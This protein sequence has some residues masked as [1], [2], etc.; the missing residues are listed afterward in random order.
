MIKLVNVSK[1]YSTKTTITQALRNINIEFKPGEF[2]AITGESGSGK[3]TLLNIISGIDTYEDGD[4]YVDGIAISNFDEENLEKYRKENIAFI[5]QNN[6][7]IDSYTVIK[8]VE[9]ALVIQGIDKEERIRRSKEIIDKVGL[10]SRINSRASKLSGG[11]KQRLAIARAL[12]MDTKIIIADEPTGSLDSKTG[13]QIVKLLS[14][15][16]KDRLVLVVTH[17]YLQIAPFV[18][19]KVRIYNGEVVEDEKLKQVLDVKPKEVLVKEEN[20]IKKS[21]TLSLFNLFGQPKKSVFFILISFVLVFFVFFIYSYLLDYVDPTINELTYVNAFPERLVVRRVDGKEMTIADYE[22]LGNDRR[23]E[24]IIKE[25][26]IIDM[27]FNSH[28]I[29]GGSSFNGKYDPLLGY[30]YGESLFGRLPEAENEIVVST[31]ISPDTDI[32]IVDL[33]NKEIIFQI[34]DS[35]K[36][37]ALPLII[38]GVKLSNEMVDRVY[39]TDEGLSYIYD[40][41]HSENIALKID[42]GNSE[43]ISRFNKEVFEVHD[44]LEGFDVFSLYLEYLVGEDVE[45][46]A[47]LEGNKLDIIRIPGETDRTKIF[48]S[49][50]LYDMLFPVN[51]FIKNYQHSVILKNKFDYSALTDKYMENGYYV[52]S[53]FYDNALGV[54]S[55]EAINAFLRILLVQVIVYTV[56]FIAYLFAYLIYKIVLRTKVKDYVIFKVLGAN[57]KVIRKTITYEFL[58]SFLFAYLLFF[59]SYIF[60]NKKI[61]MLSNYRFKD[62]IIILLINLVLTLMISR[63]YLKSLRKKTIFKNLKD[64]G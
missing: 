33:L 16:S 10:T 64:M 39:L 37:V 9:T 6:N 24:K 50:E 51:K 1:Y 25:D 62:Y 31:F 56:I 17:N 8:N 36:S 29:V 7:L 27:Q 58:F 18:T 15:L 60:I 44:A 3:T 43:Y 19:R 38:T 2:V 49:Q 46:D 12:A 35:K 48:I 26:L 40:K 55:D 30:S 4:I 54:E 59:T 5:F 42:I 52:Y 14:D 41:V 11:E 53:P 63:L 45:F 28:R 20:N 23:V 61:P 34:N 32:N 22:Y 57:N 13:D 21:V 47:Y